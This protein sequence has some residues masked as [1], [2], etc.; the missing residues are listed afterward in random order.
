MK[1]L[2]V[3][4][5]L[6]L[7]F[8]ASAFVAS[9]ISANDV[10]G[11][12]WNAEKTSKIRIYLAKNGK[13]Y[14]KIEHLETPNYDDGTPRKD[15]KN[16]SSKLQSRPLLGLVIMKAYEWN[17]DEQKWEDGTIYDPTGGKTYDGYM[18]FENGNKDVLKLRGYVMGMT[19]LG[20]TSEWTRIK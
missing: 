20:R 12:Y 13:Y 2:S 9:S 7:F 16:P 3:I 4:A 8:A 1:R 14:G 5:L 15:D 10:V 18:Y 17:E 11:T 6:G 19:W